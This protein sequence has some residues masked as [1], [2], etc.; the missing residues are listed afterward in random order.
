M[1]CQRW[2]RLC[3][4]MP[5]GAEHWGDLCAQLLQDLIL[6]ATGRW[7]ISDVIR[8]DLNLSWLKPEV[9]LWYFHAEVYW[10]C[11]QAA[12][13]TSLLLPVWAALGGQ[14]LSWHGIPSAH[15]HCVGAVLSLCRMLLLAEALMTLHLPHV[16][17]RGPHSLYDLSNFDFC[18]IVFILCL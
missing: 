6:Q 15:K 16:N 4:W 3:L 1:R 14:M 5:G 13:F 2:A 10:R 17:T 9:H 11:H 18:L 7:A 8:Y 12:F